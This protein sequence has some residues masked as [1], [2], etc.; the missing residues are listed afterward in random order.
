M[1]LV[2]HKSDLNKFLFKFNVFFFLLFL[3]HSKRITKKK[4]AQTTGDAINAGV[5]SAGDA[6]A[7]A[8]KKFD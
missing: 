2:R 7:K 4:K 5:T 8:L 1:M 3:C 6:A